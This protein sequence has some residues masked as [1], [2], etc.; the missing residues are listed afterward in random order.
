MMDTATYT[1]SGYL[2]TLGN[3]ADV[4]EAADRWWLWT[5]WDADTEIDEVEYAR[6]MLA[7]VEAE[8]AMGSDDYTDEDVANYRQAVTE[9]A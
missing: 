5:A 7:S 8:I 1:A 2:A 6:V 9:A 3:P 4:I